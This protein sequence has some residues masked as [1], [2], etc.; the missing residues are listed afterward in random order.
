M[1]LVTAG[2]ER[3]RV[4]CWCVNAILKKMTMIEMRESTGRKKII[5]LLVIKKIKFKF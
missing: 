4:K 3:E 5:R 2:G 1:V